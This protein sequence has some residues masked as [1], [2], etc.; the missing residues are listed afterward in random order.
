MRTQADSPVPAESCGWRALAWGSRPLSRTPEL[1]AHSHR[2]A[3][4]VGVWSL[5]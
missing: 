5:N 3:S 1:Q 2:R 4:W